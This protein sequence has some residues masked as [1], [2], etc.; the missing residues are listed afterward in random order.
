MCVYICTSSKPITGGDS[1]NEIS[2]ERGARRIGEIKLYIPA[3]RAAAR[4][5]LFWCFVV[6]VD[7]DRVGGRE[8]GKFLFFV[9]VFLEGRE[10]IYKEFLG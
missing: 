6:A 1:F 2:P 4:I 5:E 3:V 8:V 9:V 10:A 7:F